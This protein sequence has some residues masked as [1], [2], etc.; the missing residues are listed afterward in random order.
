MFKPYKVT[1]ETNDFVVYEFRT[2]YL[3]AMYCILAIMAAGYFARI[4]ALLV[5]GAVLLGLYLLLVT[6]QHMKVGRITGRAALQNSIEISGS[7]W[8]FTHPLRIKVK[9][10]HT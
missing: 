10:Q 3:Y 2:I 9:R 6:T 7:K 8:S 1:E 4:S 5:A